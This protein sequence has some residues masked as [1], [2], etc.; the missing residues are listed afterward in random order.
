MRIGL[1]VIVSVAGLVP[2]LLAAVTLARTGMQN[3]PAAITFGILI[4]VGCL[5]GF[6]ITGDRRLM[7]IGQGAYI[8]YAMYASM[9]PHQGASVAQIIVV[10]AVCVLLGSLPRIFVEGG[11][12]LDLVADRVLI[13]L[14]VPP[15]VR[16]TDTWLESMPPVLSISGMILAVMVVLL[17][18]ITLMG[19]YQYERAGGRLLALIRDELQ[20]RWPFQLL[21]ALFGVIVAL[22]VYA[23]GLLGLV[24]AVVPAGVT[25]VAI[26]RWSAVRSTRADTVRSLSRIPELG[27]YVDP[28]HSRRVGDLV[29]DIARELGISEL[30]SR[31]AVLAAMM[32]DIGQLSLAE[33]VPGGTTS[34][35][36]QEEQRRIARLGAEVIREGGGLDDVATFVERFADPYRR[37]DGRR[38]DNVPLESRI[39]RVA[40]A[41]DDL[42]GTSPDPE[43]RLQALERVELALS[44]DYDPDVTKALG[45]VIE[46]RQRLPVG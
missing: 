17:L 19:L 25:Q 42:V 22:T 40:N 45:R 37:P 11:V 12:R 36:D 13:L 33:P 46:R 5:L 29:L 38:D 1:R 32:H 28:G 18:Q 9:V 7:P 30:R 8:G 34:L 21:G 44:R 4:V 10:G 16:W 26:L 23:V 43:L 2:L 20:V 6:V 31:R 39:I 24:V 15:V 35:L 3:W 41:Y 27:G 14:L